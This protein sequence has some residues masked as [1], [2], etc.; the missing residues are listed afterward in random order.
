[1]F[2]VSRTAAN[3][4]N[5]VCDLFPD[6]EDVVSPETR[7]LLLFHAGKVGEV[8][9]LPTV[10]REIMA[11]LGD[12][13]VG[14]AR[15]ALSARKDPAMAA[16]LLRV[17]NSAAF[18]G[19]APVSSIREALVR[20]G[21]EGTKRFLYQTSTARILAVKARPE[22]AARLQER[23]L[24]GDT[25]RRATRHLHRANLLLA[26]VHPHEP[27]ISSLPDDGEP[28]LPEAQA[29]L[30]RQP[31][32]QGEH[33]GLSTVAHLHAARG[34]E[35]RHLGAVR[36]HVHRFGGAVEQPP[37]SERR[38]DGLHES[39]G[40][41]H[42]QHL[43]IGRPRHTAG[44]LAGNGKH[45]LEGLPRVEVV[46]VAAH[47]AAPPRRSATMAAASSGLTGMG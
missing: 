13:S 9:L 18:G 17:A 23:P 3:Y 46:G 29:R 34:G 45:R 30:P 20:I 36:G 43:T 42:E 37:R 35:H 26:F 41:G 6:E 19:A 16:N 1:M 5:G 7:E 31:C 27:L 22:L 12:P 15:V 24:V 39:A 2:N 38:L 28:P 14:M 21:I 11:M 4:G 40:V 10:A 44:R 33:G 32:F 8:P 47:Q 25:E